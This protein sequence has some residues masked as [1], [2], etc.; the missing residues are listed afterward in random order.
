MRR[1]R[2]Q[3]E[4]PWTWS[5]RSK[6]GP[7]Q[8]PGPSANVRA[9]RLAPLEFG[10]LDYAQPAD[11]LPVAIGLDAEPQC[12]VTLE[13]GVLRSQR[14]G[15][16]HVVLFLG[17]AEHRPVVIDAVPAELVGPALHP[18]AE[19]VSLDGNLREVGIEDA[20]PLLPEKP[21]ELL[22]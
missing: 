2:P 22:R 10:L 1:Q 7:P 9:F 5:Q 17:L 18:E 19:G 8:V 12:F 6:G 13:R 4:P 11:D 20:R 3:K 16:D 15:V 21:L 14:G